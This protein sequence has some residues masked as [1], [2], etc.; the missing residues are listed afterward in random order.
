MKLPPF[1]SSSAVSSDQCVQVS[2][3]TLCSAKKCES[4]CPLFGKLSSQLRQGFQR[5]T[6]ATKCSTWR[7][8]RT[9]CFLHKLF[10]SILLI[11]RKV[12]ELTIESRTLQQLLGRT[13]TRS[14][15]STRS[16]L[17]H[18]LDLVQD[19]L[20]KNMPHTYA[21]AAQEKSILIFLVNQGWFIFA[22]GIVANILLS[23]DVRLFVNTYKGLLGYSIMMQTRS[24][25]KDTETCRYWSCFPSTAAA[26]F[27]DNSSAVHSQDFS[28]VLIFCQIVAHM[29]VKNVANALFI[30]SKKDMKIVTCS[31]ETLP[32][33]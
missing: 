32:I 2:C 9:K 26:W 3:R 17:Y 16:N 14:R 18:L 23:G 10:I 29:H 4:I 21:T 22:L 20:L 31:T 1:F 24:R 8:D 25:A 15:I 28:G 6:I 7:T 5:K 27:S 19:K 13:M 11:P 30:Y 12:A 33:F